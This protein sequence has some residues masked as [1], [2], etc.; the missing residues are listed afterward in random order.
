MATKKYMGNRGLKGL[1][2]YKAVGF[3]YR[4]TNTSSP[5]LGYICFPLFLVM[6][7][8]VFKLLLNLIF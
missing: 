2:S 7:G 3:V 6:F 4:K 5:L 8:I 1:L